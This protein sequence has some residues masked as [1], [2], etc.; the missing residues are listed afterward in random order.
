MI[1]DD[2]ISYLLVHKIN[3]YFLFELQNPAPALPPALAPQQPLHPPVHPN[4]APATSGNGD[5]LVPL[6][7]V[8]R[9]QAVRPADS[10][11]SRRWDPAGRRESGSRRGSRPVTRREEPERRTPKFNEQL[12]PLSLAQELLH[13]SGIVKCLKG[14]NTEHSRHMG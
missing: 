10:A 14:H 2:L 11:G 7:I 9:L 5:V 6:S 1:F 13:V 4:P 3:I 8:D 12:I